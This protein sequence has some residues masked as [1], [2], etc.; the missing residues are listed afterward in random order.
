MHS[1]LPHKPCNVLVFRVHD[2]MTPDT[3][4]RNSRR[5]QSSLAPDG[6]TRL[7]VEVDG[8]RHMDPELLRE[9]L[10]FIEPV[11]SRLDRI[12]VVGSRVWLKS[13]IKLGGIPFPSSVEYFDRGDSE[14]AWRWL[15]E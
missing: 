8:F 9:N 13:W 3:R 10:R 2:E 12:A 6:P 15:N 11:A 1:A 7:L 14:S 5:L 4:D